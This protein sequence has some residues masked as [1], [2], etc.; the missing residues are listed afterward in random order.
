MRILETPS[1][2]F[3]SRPSSM[4]PFPIFSA[5]ACI[6]ILSGVPLTGSA[7]DPATTTTETSSVTT[8]GGAFPTPGL[9]V[10]PTAAAA[11]L[12]ATNVSHL[13]QLVR[14]VAS[15]TDNI[16]ASGNFGAQL[17]LTAN[18]NFAE[19]WRKPEAPTIE[20][21]EMVQRGQAVYTAIIFYGEAR[22]PA[23]LGNVSY[24]VTILRPDGTIYN[25][26]DALIGF[27]NL[28]PTDERELQL[29]RN[30]L[31]INIGADDPA[32]LYTVSVIVHDNVSRV[33]LAL[34]QTFVVE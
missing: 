13:R 29:G 23:G 22:T 6:L 28:A 8:P 5:A 18:A 27:Q 31:S 33:D 16:R 3:S 17:W 10:P 15:N 11:K 2:F 9:P 26:R 19:D 14:D 34:K 7:Q 12:S 4:K 1:V 32:G 21:V 24:D 20:P 30:N 25:R